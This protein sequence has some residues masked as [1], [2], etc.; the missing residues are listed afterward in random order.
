MVVLLIL[1]VIVMMA[2]A[3][4]ITIAIPIAIAPLIVTV[5]VTM[6]LVT[7]AN[8]VKKLNSKKIE[9]REIN[10]KIFKIYCC[11]LVSI[12]CNP[13]ML[14]INCLPNTSTTIHIQNCSIHITARITT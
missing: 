5:T 6:V 3:I 2:I 11:F 13:R 9:N 7:I 1:T 4:M 12:L 14:E 8:R 10:S